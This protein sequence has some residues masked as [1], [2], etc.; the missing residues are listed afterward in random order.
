MIDDNEVVEYIFK[1]ATENGVNVS[2]E[3]II[4]VIDY[5]FE[6]LRLKGVLA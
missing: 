2:K 4:K 1:K 5:E 3:D 6:F